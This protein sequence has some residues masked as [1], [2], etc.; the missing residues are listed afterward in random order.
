MKQRKCTDMPDELWPPINSME[1][2]VISYRLTTKKGIVHSAD[3][4]SKYELDKAKDRVNKNLLGDDRYYALS[5]FED[6]EDA[7]QLL[8]MQGW[9]FKGIARGLTKSE[10]G[11]IR[12]T[13]SED[14]QS[15]ISWWLYED[16][17]PEKYFEILEEAIDE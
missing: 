14:H 15:H 4:V 16:A 12:F 7:E 6:Q 9:R 8:R 13:P 5:V 2:D 11:C 17:A 10:D 3:F 1:K